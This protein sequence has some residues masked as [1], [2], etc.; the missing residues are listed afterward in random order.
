MSITTSSFYVTGGNL[1]RDAPSYVEREADRALYDAL[2]RGEFCYVLDARQMGKSSLMVR[3]AARLR[4]S[5]IRIA[6]VDL[7]AIGQNLTAEQWYFGLLL[8]LGRAL[9]LEDELEEFWMAHERLSPLQRWMEALRQVVLPGIG[10]QVFRGSGVQEEPCPTPE[11]LNTRTPEYPDRLVIFIDEID[12][13]RSLPFSTDEFFAAIRECYNRRTK[14]PEFHRLTFCLLGVATPSDLIQDTRTT[15]FNIGRRIELTDFT[16]AEAAPLALGLLGGTLPGPPLRG[17]APPPLEGEG[18][19]APLPSA[20]NTDRSM[21][22]PSLAGKGA[23]GLGLLQRILYWTGGHPYLTQRLCRAIAES[24]AQSPNP[25]SAI[26]GTLWVPQSVDRLCEELLLSHRGREQDDNLI[27]VRER[28]LRAGA[29]AG[30]GVDLAALLEL[31]A[32]VRK[33]RKVLAD[34]A[35]PLVEILRLSGIA[36]V[37]DGVLRVRNRIY[38]WVFNREWITQHMPDAE[39]RRQRAAFRRG[40]FRTTAVATVIVAAMAGLSLVAVTQARH[41]DQQRRLAQE[42]QRKLRRSLYAARMKLAQQDWEEDGSTGTTLALLDGLRPEPGQEDLRGFEWRY[43]WRR[44]QEGDAFATWDPGQ[45]TLSTVAFSSDG[46][47]LATAGNSTEIKL[48]DVPTQRAV[49]PLRRHG[50]GDLFPGFGFSPDGML[51]ASF[52][53]DQIVRL[54]DVVTRREVGHLAVKGEEA[55]RDRP[56]GPFSCLCLSPDGHLLATGSFD[57]RVRLWDVRARRL[58]A[59]FTGHQDGISSLVFSPDGKTLASG[60]WFDSVRL[61][62]LTTRGPGY[63]RSG[64]TPLKGSLTSV[65]SIAFSPDGKTL[66]TAGRE[67]FDGVVKL[68]D[69]ATRR[70]SGEELWGHR[71]WVHC[72]RFSP[73]GK[74]LASGGDDQIIRIWNVA[75]HRQVRALRGHRRAV[76]SLAFSPDGT[77]LA[78][79]SGDRTVKLWKLADRGDLTSVLRAGAPVSAVALSPDGGMLAAAGEDSTVRLWEIATRRQIAS[80]KTPQGGTH[81]IAFSPDGKL[82][83]VPTWLGYSNRHVVKLWDVATRREL[84]AIPSSTT[85]Y[86]VPAFSPD[87]R[88]LATVKDDQTVLVWDLKARRQRAAVRVSEEPGRIGIAFAPDGTGVM[89]ANNKD[90]HGAVDLWDIGT[91]R[92]VALLR[93]VPAE[94]PFLFSPDGRLLATSNWSDTLKLWD[95][96]T[97]QAVATLKRESPARMEI[98]FS[99]D[100]R[101]LAMTNGKNISLWDLTSQQEVASLRGHTGPV[102]GVAFS[103]DGNLLASGSADGTVRLWRAASFQE[104][105]PLR[106]VAFGSD[107][108]VKLEWKPVSSASGYN[109]YRRSGVQVFRLVD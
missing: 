72:V 4:R 31:Y 94:G 22:P 109:V 7:T 17:G 28:L 86:P 84:S 32:R 6:A 15:P 65:A 38:A 10:V 2:C 76:N 54:W 47:M 26:P 104:T 9:D 20:R 16:A 102:S 50:D 88:L 21:A 57:H 74:W 67:G 37:S 46:R 39:L 71:G 92:S 23:G 49:A 103:P 35:D 93:D 83:A 68:W 8:Q 11:P 58:L 45:G 44:C 98:A 48:W 69:V 25:Q 5:D 77:T 61:W 55:P 19:H 53:G 64:L 82:L 30:G 59:T 75:T 80:L 34:R 41:A 108:A 99:P 27:F 101:S 107:R 78:S 91:R 43:L 3:T 87:S 1:E 40:V 14:E 100:N 36:R 52:S 29:P 24:S 42:G 18:S 81:Q 85:L 95:W 90:N 60:S 73:D 63:P 12:A 89:V 62:N 66:A 105:D 96:R 51:L 13:V 56:V 97:K 70:P 33:R 79:C 106:V